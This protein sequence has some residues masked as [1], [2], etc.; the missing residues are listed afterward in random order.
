MAEAVPPPAEPEPRPL[1]L[2]AHDGFTQPIRGDAARDAGPR[3]PVLDDALPWE[4]RP[5]EQD[6]DA[7]D[8]PT[9]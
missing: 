2:P 4:D 9:P 5:P 6:D 1:D 7:G 3:H 8:V